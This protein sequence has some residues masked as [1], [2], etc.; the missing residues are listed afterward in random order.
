[1]R[2]S[3]QAGKNMEEEKTKEKYVKFLG[4]KL[5]IYDK[6]DEIPFDGI[7]FENGAPIEVSLNYI[8]IEKLQ[9]L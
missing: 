8:S 7:I 5:K 6:G 4:Y 3:G 2:L 9:N 1:M